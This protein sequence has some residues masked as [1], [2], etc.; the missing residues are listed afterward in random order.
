MKVKRPD[1]NNNKTGGKAEQASYPNDRVTTARLRDDGE[2]RVPFEFAGADRVEKLA[3]TRAEF[4]SGLDDA[5]KVIAATMAV[6]EQLY[7]AQ[8]GSGLAG[9]LMM[10]ASLGVGS[11]RQAMT[12]YALYAHVRVAK[13]TYMLEVRASES[14]A[15]ASTNGEG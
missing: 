2:V 11:F 1:N 6:G 4:E 14:A 12:A 8:V 7:R 10:A 9:F 13:H 15:A 5:R 3:A